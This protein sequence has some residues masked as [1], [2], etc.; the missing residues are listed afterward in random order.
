MTGDNLVFWFMPS[1][2]A[3][4]LHY[5]RAAG[6]P[7]TEQEVLQ[8]REAAACVATPIELV[9]HLEDQRGYRDI[10]PE[11]CWDEW[12]RVR[13]SLGSSADETN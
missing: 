3:V 12:Q 8:I 5:E 7:L 9:P 11:R 4:L 1:L 6:R 13:L 10:D 2:T